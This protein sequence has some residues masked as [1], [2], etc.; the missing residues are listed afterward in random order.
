MTE[1]TGGYTQQLGGEKQSLTVASSKLRRFDTRRDRRSKKA[2]P[3]GWRSE[4]TE[5]L[6]ISLELSRE[7]TE[8]R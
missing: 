2:V 3:V 7:K 4:S 5:I 1:G 8:K 6:R